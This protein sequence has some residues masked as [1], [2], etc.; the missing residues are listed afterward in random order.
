MLSAK[1]F[2]TSLILTIFKIQVLV[3]SL[4]RKKTKTRASTL[5]SRERRNAER[6]TLPSHSHAG[7][8]LT[9]LQRLWEPSQQMTGGGLGRQAGRSC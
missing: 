5:L 7:S 3:S 2:L 8:P 1:A 6:F 4:R 9:P